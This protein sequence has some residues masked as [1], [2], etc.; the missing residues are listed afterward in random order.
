MAPHAD[1]NFPSINLICSLHVNLSSILFQDTSY[2]LLFLFFN[3]L[4][5][6]FIIFLFNLFFIS[7]FFIYNITCCITY[8]LSNKICLGEIGRRGKKSLQTWW[9][10]VTLVI[11]S[12][13]SHLWS[14]KIWYKNYIF[15]FILG[16]FSYDMTQ[17]KFDTRI[18]R[19]WTGRNEEDCKHK[20]F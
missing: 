11:Y 1:N 18:L 19:K 6:L 10:A 4:F 14:Q 13:Q 17:S 2:T 16:L 20:Y 5:Y 9:S 3:I 8:I 7:I 15:P 12:G